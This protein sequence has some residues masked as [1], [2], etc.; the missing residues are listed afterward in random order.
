MYKYQAGV[1]TVQIP[2]CRKISAIDRNY[3]ARQPGGQV[4]RTAVLSINATQNDGKTWL[5]SVSQCAAKP[6]S[7]R[8]QSNSIKECGVLSSILF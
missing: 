4:G 2:K 1:E 8:P 5:W 7:D 6:S 3:I